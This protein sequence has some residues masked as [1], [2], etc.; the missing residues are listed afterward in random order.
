M[1]TGAIFLLIG[2]L[3]VLFGGIHKLKQSQREKRSHFVEE[4]KTNF[5]EKFDSVYVHHDTVSFYNNG[6]LKGRTV[7]K[8]N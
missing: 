2:G 1:N 7:L 6:V 5:K 8:K 3:V 4:A